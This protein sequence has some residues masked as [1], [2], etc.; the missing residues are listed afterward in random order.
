MSEFLDHM[1]RWI[2]YDA[3][4]DFYCKH[5]PSLAENAALTLRPM[6][7]ADLGE[8]VLI[9]QQ[10]YTHPW[11]AAT[12]RDC[13]KIGYHA[14]IGEKAGNTVGY[15]ILSVGAGECHLLNICVK[16]DLQGQ[17]LGRHLLENL[18]EV[19]TRQRA[20]TMFLEVRASNRRAVVLY[21]RAGFNEIGLRKGYYPADAGREDAIVMARML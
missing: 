14:F 1:K 7:K 21:Q 18:I 10:A 8:V 11:D 4:R 15:G 20:E 3:E 17:G 2:S 19:A 9:E 13:F 12:F 16:T 5:F 6:R